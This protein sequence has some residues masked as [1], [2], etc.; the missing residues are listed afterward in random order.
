MRTICFG[1]V[2]VAI[3]LIEVHAASDFAPVAPPSTRAGHVQPP[4]YV[5]GELLVKFKGGPLSDAANRARSAYG[6]TI[7]RNFEHIGWQHIQ[8]PPGLSVKEALS[9]YSKDPDIAAV[10]P[11]YVLQR[12][13]PRSTPLP[14][15]PPKPARKDLQPVFPSDLMF[16]QQ[17]ALTNI[18]AQYAWGIDVGST[19]VVA[20]VIDTGVNYNHEDLAANMWHNPGEIPGNGIDDDGDGYVDNVFGADVYSNN[21]DP[22]DQGITGNFPTCYHGTG[23]ASI[24]GGVGNNGVG[25]TG[26]NW[27]VRLM[28]VRNGG[29]SGVVYTSDEIACLNYVLG[30]RQRGINVRVINESLG[31]TTWNG[32]WRDSINALGDAG[33]MVVSIAHNFAIDIDVTPYYPAAFDCPNMISVAASTSSDRLAD[34]S[35]WGHTN[36]DLTAPGQDIVMASGPGPTNYAIDYGTSY[37]APHV[38]GAVA[39]LAAAYPEATVAQ[40]KAAILDTVDVIEPF[41]GLTVTGGRLNVARALLYLK[42]NQPPVIIVSPQ[43]TSVLPGIGT[44]LAVGAGGTPPLSYQWFQG[45]GIILDATNATLKMPVILNSQSGLWVQ[46][47]NAFGI[48]NSE[49]V[50][51]SVDPTL[52]P[53]V[54]WGANQYGQCDTPA[55]LTNVVAIAGG[56][57]HSVALCSDGTVRAWGMNYWN[58]LEVPTNLSGVKA[59]AAGAYHGLALQTNGT[60]TVWGDNEYDQLNIPSGLS[61]I[62]S[63]AAGFIH[64]LALR[65]NGTVVAWGYNDFGQC[66][67]PADLVGVAAVATGYKHNLALLTNGTVVA[68]GSN[69]SGERNVPGDLEGVSAVVAGNRI[70][71]ALKYDG[72]VVVW[73]SNLHGALDVPLGLSN[74]VA[75]AGYSH[76]MALRRDGTVVAWGAGMTN[77]ATGQDWGQAIVPPGL[78]NV[79]ATSSHGRHSLA[80]VAQP[81][82]PVLAIQLE[83][84]NVAVTW[85]LSAAG[86]QLLSTTNLIPSATWQPWLGPILTNQ[87]TLSAPVTPGTENRFFRLR[88]P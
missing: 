73:G 49:P 26:I 23:I 15:K 19:D 53:V 16:P 51:V 31:G 3:S 25:V 46:I 17:W 45:T 18:C 85:P 59:I 79:M 68:W 6:L 65:S 72:T 14:L 71:M 40:L 39:L 9:L 76:F 84:M 56:L 28:A 58:Q 61:G 5:E 69:D 35:D 36:V 81:P 67:V 30:M 10:Q 66:D 2:V 86:W 24:I 41:Q 13:I 7:K 12:E 29:A 37:A 42:T 75:I 78:S 48:T 80:L 88:G 11:N 34:F 60:V 52:P 57:W 70:S 38:A 47:S 8:L 82:P 21:G 77:A 22:M 33:V 50:Q 27:I 44:S 64:S 55:D 74:V 4:E 20:V 54:G 62:A 1:V 83:G 43:S 63:I 32:S 87:G